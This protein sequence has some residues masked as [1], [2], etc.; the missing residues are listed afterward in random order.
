MSLTHETNK[1]NQKLQHHQAHVPFMERRMLGLFGYL[2]LF[3]IIGVIALSCLSWAGNKIWLSYQH[4]IYHQSLEIRNLADIEDTL[5]NIAKDVSLIREM[6]MTNFMQ[7]RAL[8]DKSQS[9]ALDF[10][11][12]WDKFNLEN[13]QSKRPATCQDTMMALETKLDG[14]TSEKIS[15]LL[16]VWEKFEN[17]FRDKTLIAFKT[18]L[19]LP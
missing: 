1:D 18:N 2:N 6:T 10:T 8:Q 11:E 4:N 13:F 12:K 9:L 5:E 17:D 16:K 3:L 7:I 14:K 19:S 15:M